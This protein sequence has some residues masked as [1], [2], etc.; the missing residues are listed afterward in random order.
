M[1][2]APSVV[3]RLVFFKRWFELL[4][5]IVIVVSSVLTVS[6]ILLEDHSAVD[7]SSGA[8]VVS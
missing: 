8:T 6:F 1:F 7:S 5:L 4:D 3:C 2:S